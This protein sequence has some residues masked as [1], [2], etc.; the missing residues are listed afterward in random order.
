[1]C[2]QVCIRCVSGVYQVCMRCVSGV[3]K[4]K[5]RRE[6]EKCE[7]ITRYVAGHAGRAEHAGNMTCDISHTAYDTVRTCRAI[8][9]M[10]TVRVVFIV[11]TSSISAPAAA[12]ANT[13]VP[14]STCTCPG[15]SSSC[16]IG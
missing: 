6:K 14:R 4:K 9:L 12:A 1:M 8:I 7:H 16:F 15:T 5:R 13:L 3:S 2:I 10:H 11:S